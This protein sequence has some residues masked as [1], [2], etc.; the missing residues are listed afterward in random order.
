[1]RPIV[2]LNKMNSRK[3]ISYVIGP[4]DQDVLKILSGE[5]TNNQGEERVS[6]MDWVRLCGGI[7]K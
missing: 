5:D 1:M 3:G 7:Y 6:S 2:C 4:F